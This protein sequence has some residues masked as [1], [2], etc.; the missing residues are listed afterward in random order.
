MLTCYDATF[1]QIIDK[2]GVD[3]VLVGDSLGMVIGG[4]ETTLGVTL[5]EV[6]YHTKAVA[7]G[8][9]RA[10]IVADMPFMTYQHDVRDAL[11]NGAALMK[12]GAHS[13]KLEG[14][15]ELSVTVKALTTAGIPV[16]AHVGLTPQSVHMLSGFRIQGKTEE[17]ARRIMEDAIALQEAGAYAVVLE[18]IPPVLAE[19]VTSELKIPTIGIGSG[20]NCDGQ[21]LVLYDVLGL[22]PEYAPKF[23][24]QYLNGGTLALQACEN[25]V[26]EVRGYS[27]K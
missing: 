5:D 27:V 10:H 7:R 4:Q 12:A 23:A 2:S 1:G 9:K 14:G 18:C 13:V 22:N 8:V 21:V 11:L 19:L 20:Q 24:K 17:S 15:A 3:L 25:F 16:M 6:I 26:A